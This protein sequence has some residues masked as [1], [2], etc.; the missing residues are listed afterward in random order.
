MCHLFS[1]IELS[2]NSVRAELQRQGRRD[3]ATQAGEWA[4]GATA[5]YFSIR[6]LSKW[7][8]PLEVYKRPCLIKGNLPPTPYPPPLSL[9]TF[10]KL[11][12]GAEGQGAWTSK[13]KSLQENVIVSG[14]ADDTL[15]G[16]RGRIC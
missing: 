10:V 11:V 14:G 6:Q 7:S 9:W 5:L 16:H 2:A 8:G 15:L 4:V 1:Q 12:K 3:A 13:K